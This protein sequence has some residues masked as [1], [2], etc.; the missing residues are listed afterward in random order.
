MR[1]SILTSPFCELPPDAI[2]AIEIRWMNCAVVFSK[3]KHF[4]Q[5]IGKKG[6]TILP[7]ESFFEHTYVRGYKRTG[8]VYLDIVLDFFYT[9]RALKCLKKC[10]VLVV[11]TF[12]A[13]ILAPL[14]FRNRYHRLVYNVARFPKRHMFFYRHVDMFVCTSSAIKKKFIELLPSLRGIRCE[15]VN[16]PIDVSTFNREHFLSIDDRQMIIGYHGRIHREK[17]LHLLAAAVKK[18][19]IV[20]PNIRIKI[21]GSWDI[22]RGGSGLSYKE[23]LDAMSDNRIEWVPPISDRKQLAAALR[24]CL[25]Y[26]YPS[27]AERGETF[28]VAPLEAMGLGL[29]V[30]VSNLECFRD[31]VVPG[32]NSL[33]FDHKKDDAVDVLAELLRSLMSVAKVRESIGNAAAET[34]SCFSTDNIA[35][36]YINIFE[37]LLRS[38][39]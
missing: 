25:V 21:I 18:C 20:I 13:P 6:S 26:C 9:I 7:D 4:V 34:A 30:V 11:N 22:A 19:A 12:W 33:V 31:Y 10:D 29:P 36:K 16:N 14:L 1:I 5:M 38:G 2:G 27:I 17:G 24:T 8:S 32:V 15:V 39:K 23:K 37:D 28:G 3:M 35:R